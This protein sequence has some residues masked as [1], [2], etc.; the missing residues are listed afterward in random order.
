M[1]CGVILPDGTPCPCTGTVRQINSHRTR[2][3]PKTDLNKCIITNECPVCNRVFKETGKDGKTGTRNHLLAGIGKNHC[4]RLVAHTRKFDSLIKVVPVPRHQC[5]F[6]D[7]LVVGH[8]KVMA[9]IKKHF[10]ECYPNYEV[11][12]DDPPAPALPPPPPPAR[13]PA[14]QTRQETCRR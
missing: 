7:E 6:C 13:C 2:M 12:S 8:T 5:E 10:L 4:P 1:T 11:G 9:H 14:T 3:H